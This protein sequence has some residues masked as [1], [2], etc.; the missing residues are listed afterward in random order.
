MPQRI[1]LRR[2]AGWRKPEHAVVV[3]RPTCWGNPHPIGEHTVEAHRAS[4]EAF[5]RDLLGGALPYT[6]DDVRRALAG[7]DLACWCRPELPCHADVLLD[8]ANR[9]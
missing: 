2:T 6:A 7:K 4:V 3:A 8:L 5:R 1:Q 9:D